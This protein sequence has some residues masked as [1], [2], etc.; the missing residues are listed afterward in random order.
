MFSHQCFHQ[1]QFTC[2]QCVI[3]RYKAYNFFQISTSHLKVSIYSA[4]LFQNCKILLVRPLLKKGKIFPSTILWMQRLSNSTLTRFLHSLFLMILQQG[5]LAAHIQCVLNPPPHNLNLRRKRPQNVV[6]KVL[7]ISNL[8]DWAVL[9][10]K[11][12][13]KLR[14]CAV[15]AVTLW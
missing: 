6:V 1:Y 13:N 2:V 5:F 10:I 12:L 3:I 8:E 9:I 14:N 7:H 15:D 4:Y 11:Q